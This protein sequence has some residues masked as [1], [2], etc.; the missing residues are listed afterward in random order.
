MSDRLDMQ[1][2]ATV[3]IVALEPCCVCHAASDAVGV[4]TP[5]EDRAAEFGAPPGRKR[6]IFYAI[7][8]ECL[9]T[10]QAQERIEAVLRRGAFQIMQSP[11]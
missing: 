7:C 1:L 3:A 6:M 11:T 2:R 9:D 10:P 5:D 8:S 4:F